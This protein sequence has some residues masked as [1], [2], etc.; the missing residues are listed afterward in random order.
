MLAVFS[1]FILLTYLLFFGSSKSM[2]FGYPY[3]TPLRCS[4]C[5]LNA[6]CSVWIR[7]FYVLAQRMGLH[8]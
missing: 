7:G 6:N 4:G 8:R 2:Q 5:Y 3:T 1:D